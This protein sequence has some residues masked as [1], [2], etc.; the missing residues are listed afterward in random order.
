VNQPRQATIHIKNKGVVQLIITNFSHS[1][2][3]EYSDELRPITP[4]SPLV[5]NPG[6]GYDFLV[7]FIPCDSMQY[8][9][10]LFFTSNT[11]KTNNVDSTAIL[12]GKGVKFTAVSDNS[13][14]NK[15]IYLY[16]NPAENYLMIQFNNLNSENISL[17]I[18]DI[19]GNLVDELNSKNQNINYNTSKLANGLYII[20]LNTGKKIITKTF[21]VLK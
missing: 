7:D 3:P 11:D 20:Q 8:I 9:D 5:L 13:S 1:K 16:P 21:I 4:K 18:M 15:E 6:Q 14:I 19:Y 17:R 2:L 10:T 12:T